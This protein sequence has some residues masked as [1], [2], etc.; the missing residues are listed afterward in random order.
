MKLYLGTKLVNIYMDNKNID[1]NPKIESTELEGLVFRSTTIGMD[2]IENEELK[3]L[4][5]NE[6]SWT[7]M[8]QFKVVNNTYAKLITSTGFNL[9]ISYNRNAVI[10][11]LIESSDGINYKR[12]V[13]EI[14][15]T[16]D[17]LGESNKFTATAS[18]DSK[19]KKFKLYIK[20]KI[21]KGS[22]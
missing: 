17:V 2:S 10:V 5:E 7:V 9:E 4:I 15:A 14:R 19:L 18:Y 12:N 13:Q 3:T 1:I 22:I 6:S 20:Y 11:T 16:T 8:S 21:K